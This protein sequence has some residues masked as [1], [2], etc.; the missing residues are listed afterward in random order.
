MIV[1]L[2]RKTTFSRNLCGTMKLELILEID[3]ITSLEI[4]SKTIYAA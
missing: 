2:L 3:E 1:N 4:T